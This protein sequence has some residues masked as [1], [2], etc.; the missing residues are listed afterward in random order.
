M[1]SSHFT[2]E[3]TSQQAQPTLHSYVQLPTQV[4]QQQLQLQVQ[5]FLRSK[6]TQPHEIQQQTRLYIQHTESQQHT[7]N[8]NNTLHSR[9]YYQ[10]NV[11]RIK[12]IMYYHRGLMREHEQVL[13]DIQQEMS[14]MKGM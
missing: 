4:I 7:T 9:E 12:E 6:Q 3:N 1:P 13:R 2:V 5:H 8:T 14:A 11:E 10:A